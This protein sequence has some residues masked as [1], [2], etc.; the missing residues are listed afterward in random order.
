MSLHLCRDVSPASWIAHT[1][2]PDSQLLGFG[3]ADFDAYARLRFIPDP[4][5]PGQEETDADIEQDHPHDREQTRRALDLLGAFTSTPDD[6]YFCVWDGWTQTGDFASGRGPWVVTPIR[7]FLL[8][9]GALSDV[10]SGDSILGADGYL[11]AFA[12]P[13]DRSWLFTKDVDPH[14]A[15]IGGSPA[16]IDALLASND[17]DVVRA[18]PS[19][20]QPHYY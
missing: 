7:R 18:Q 11:P 13:A 15:G 16:A 3:P 14:W 17:L 2:L 5:R 20:P 9:R 12:W 4:T 10:G 8:F 19:E 6:L 1:G